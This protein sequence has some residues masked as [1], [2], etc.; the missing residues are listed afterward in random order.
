M[1]TSG[2]N[3]RDTFSIAGID[4]CRSQ[5]NNPVEVARILGIEAARACLLREL[6]VVMQFDGS[7]VNYRHMATL[8]DIMTQSGTMMAINRHGLNRR[9]TGPLM[10]ATLEESVT[11]LMDAGCYSEFDPLSGPSERVAI[12]R[13]IFQGTGMSS[14]YLIVDNDAANARRKQYGYHAGSQYADEKGKKG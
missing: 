1:E 13:P 5:S 12:G 7:Y 14:R 11:M 3:L 10:R 4:H 8:C 6:R 9:Q 2:S